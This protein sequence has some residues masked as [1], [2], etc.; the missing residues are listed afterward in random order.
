MDWIQS[1]SN[2]AITRSQDSRTA[3]VHGNDEGSYLAYD[4]AVLSWWSILPHGPSKS[5]TNNQ[6]VSQTHKRPLLQRPLQ[7]CSSKPIPS[8]SSGRS[9]IISHPPLPTSRLFP[10]A[11]LST[12]HR[13]LR[14]QCRRQPLPRASPNTPP[15]PSRKPQNPLERRR[16]RRS[17]ASRGSSLQPLG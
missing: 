5:P 16:A 8:S 10:R 13:F 6:E 12:A 3:E 2:K 11:R 15:T 4:G 1:W 7:T 17:P 9:S 14:G